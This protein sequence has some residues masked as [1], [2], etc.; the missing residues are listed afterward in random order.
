MTTSELK[1]LKPV[2]IIR[3]G[4]RN[5]LGVVL[6]IG[7]FLFLS[8]G[9]VYW[10]EA[11]VIVGLFV[12]Y[13]SIWVIWGM[14]ND[15]ALLQERAQSLKKDGKEWDKKLVQFNL[16]ISIAFYVVAGLD[17]VRFGWSQV[18]ARII[19]FALLFA[20][21]GYVLPFW[22]MTNNPFASG[23]VRIQKE[24]GHKVVSGGPYQFI[25]HPM[26][27]GTFFYG[28]GAPLY[29]GS[30]WALVPG[31][32]LITTIIIR[33]ALEDRTLQE[34]LPGYREY[35]Q[36]VRFRLIPGIW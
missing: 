21:L 1:K 12:A 5:V 24:R 8:A 16:V 32:A 7:G 15:P 6:L 30:L 26:Y 3:A 33:T 13:F 9:T 2:N 4:I 17:A 14:R 27:L 28:I 23:I 31:M 29:L 19:P 35:A 10:L 22:A 20:V 18:D 34:E 11:W 25:R 36:K